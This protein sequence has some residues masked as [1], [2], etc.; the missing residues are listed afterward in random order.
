MSS[1][2]KGFISSLISDL[3][4]AIN[5]GKLLLLLQM[6]PLFLFLSPGIPIMHLLYLS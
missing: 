2:K 6:F 1:A 3:V 5:L 4:S